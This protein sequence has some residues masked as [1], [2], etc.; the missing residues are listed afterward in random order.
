[1]LYFPRI[2]LVGVLLPLL[3]SGCGF[4]PVYGKKKPAGNVSQI[5]AGVSVDPIVG[6]DGQQ[7]RAELEDALNP[8]GRMPERPAYR[9]HIGFG[10]REVAI[11]VAR[12]ATV[13]R[14]NIYFDSNYTLYR[15]SDGKQV[16]QGAIRHIGSY[17]NAANAYFST[18]IS[19]D[20]GIKRGISELA[21]MYRM[22]LGSY[23]ASGAPDQYKEIKQEPEDYYPETDWRND[24]NGALGTSVSP[25]TNLSQ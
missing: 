19:R 2:A 21:Q 10:L 25:A 6:R 18:Y 5:Y 7:F 16:T 22:R 9:L 20:D 17:N 4:Q 11:G 15:N 8:D 12:D 23:L 3:A 24:M 1:M 13:S 14:Y